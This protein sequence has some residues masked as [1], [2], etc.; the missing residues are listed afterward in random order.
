MTTFNMSCR[1]GK[2]YLIA[3][4]LKS[5]Y[6]ELR[7]KGQTRANNRELTLDLASYTPTAE[8]KLTSTVT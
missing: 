7:V 3:F 4:E 2:I 1:G 6:I 8:N 5:N